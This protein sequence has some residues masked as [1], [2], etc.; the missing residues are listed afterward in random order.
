MKSASL[1]TTLPLLTRIRGA[2]SVAVWV[3]VRLFEG[4]ELGV[5]YARHTS[6]GLATLYSSSL[7]LRFDLA[8][9][10]AYDRAWCRR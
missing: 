10:V 4:G 8:G 3:Q 6:L 5:S 7:D 1:R 2:V 9:Q